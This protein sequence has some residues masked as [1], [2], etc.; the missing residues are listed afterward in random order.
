MVGAGAAAVSLLLCPRGC[1]SGGTDRF[2][3]STGGRSI[4][5]QSGL[6]LV[7]PDRV[8]LTVA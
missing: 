8:P 2:Y 6:V 3:W 4:E 1:R 5:D 7:A